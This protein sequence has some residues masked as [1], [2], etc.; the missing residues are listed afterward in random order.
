MHNIRAS[1]GFGVFNRLSNHI[2][3]VEFT[4]AGGGTRKN[5]YVLAKSFYV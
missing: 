1:D 4:K 2:Y 3:G 5:G